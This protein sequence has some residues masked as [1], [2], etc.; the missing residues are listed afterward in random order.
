MNITIACKNRIILKEW[1]N[2]PYGPLSFLGHTVGLYYIQ[3]GEHPPVFRPS[4]LLGEPGRM[5]RQSL[6]VELAD[7]IC[8]HT[9][10]VDTK[11][12]IERSHRITFKVWF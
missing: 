12:R 8:V 2:F 11:N 6:I 10:N 1:A 3:Y 4:E 7:W 9:G 5:S